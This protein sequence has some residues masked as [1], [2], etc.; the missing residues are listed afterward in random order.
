MVKKLEK[1]IVKFFNPRSWLYIAVIVGLIFYLYVETRE[2]LNLIVG[3]A[4]VAMLL[5]LSIWSELRKRK[6]ISNFI[7]TITFNLSSVAKDSLINFRLP[8]I[9]LEPDGGVV[10][11]N[12]LFKNMFDSKEDFSHA[13]KT[14]FD[15]KL[16][17]KALVKDELM[18]TEISVKDKKYKVLGNLTMLNNVSQ[19]QNYILMLYF[20]D[21]TELVNLRKKFDDTQLVIGSIM[22]DNYEDLQQDGDMSFS[23]QMAMQLDIKI[24]QWISPLG[25]FVRKFEKDR[26]LV[27]IEKK[28]LVELE[29]KKFEILESVKEIN[30]GN[31]Y[32]VTL[33][34]GFG[35]NG[36][37]LSGSLAYSREALDLALG[38]GG[39]QVV[40]K[41]DA[42]IRFFGGNTREVEK[43]TR[44][45]ARVVAY[46]L[47]NLI[48]DASQVFIMGHNATD[49]D[50][51]GS[52]LGLYRA[53]KSRGKDARIV[54]NASNISIDS[55]MERAS[56]DPE[57]SEVFINGN[58]ASGMV[59]DDTLLIIVD[60]HRKNYVE[61]PKL[62]DEVSKVVIIDHH[63]R[64]AD[65]I[66]DTV[67]T[68]QEVY[69]SST[70]EL[71]AE[72]LMY[73]DNNPKLKKLEAEALYAGIVVDT[74]NFTFKTGVRTFEAASFLKRH[75]V[76]TVSVKQLFQTDLTVFKAVCQT[77]NQAEI[78]K[79]NIVISTCPTEISMTQLV[80]ANAADQML[81]IA[82]VSA[83]FV[84]CQIN[85]SIYISA[86]SYGDINVQVIME[87][88]GG[89]GHMT[90]AGT[91][92]DEV[93]L[94][95]AK[96]M[97][98]QS[99]DEYFETKAD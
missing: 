25:G 51:L 41:D 95:Y 20:I 77:I 34:I 50:C 52:A 29:N 35:L 79:G 92:I 89:G 21:I 11:H 84:L 19:D 49:M 5:I 87:K 3:G 69:A 93:S 46:A 26:F 53:V 55:F 73:F 1:R 15:G 10:W 8:L 7:D 16:D 6:E 74:K 83:S 82:G 90:V 94:E 56:E 28:D 18:S 67:L 23:S 48:D 80:A 27:F 64:S 81:T 76:D 36:T 60:V 33:S 45:K 37:N 2:T 75:G 30:F 57:Y 78:I 43:R 99:I 13:V 72:L 38:R 44:V 31:K 32:P 91:K 88:L 66:A 59:D 58:M 63:R 14:L 12:E 86:R 22:V 96:K 85:S 70:C 9:L 71:V 68:Y 65:F 24:N 39:D 40:I 61:A 98:I 4:L 47:R 54:L 17:P 97:L 62:V 42:G